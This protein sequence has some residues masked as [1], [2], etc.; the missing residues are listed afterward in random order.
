MSST[1]PPIAITEY[2][3]QWPFMYEQEKARVLSVIGKWV[4]AI[5]HV[6]ST[7]VPGL[8]AKPT[9]DIQAGARSQPDTEKCIGPLE[10][11]GYEYIPELEVQMPG[12]RFFRKG[13][14]GAGVYHL[15]LKEVDSEDWH[16][17]ILFRDYLRTHTDVAN[18]YDR[19]KRELA[20][21]HGM[22][23]EGY[24]AAKAAFIES[25]VARACTEQGIDPIASMSLSVPG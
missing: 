3:P 2:D 12:T 9:I 20:A 15:H 8:G 22:D 14:R 1:R 7:A 6:G 23:R 11:I 21:T 4:V 5:E 25:V 24:T 16:R 13:P 17:F 18:E 19:L 10:S